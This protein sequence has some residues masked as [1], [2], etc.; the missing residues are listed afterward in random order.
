[1]FSPIALQ[2][3]G[4]CVERLGLWAKT[5]V[6]ARLFAHCWATDVRPGS[7]ARGAAPTLARKLLTQPTTSL[8]PSAVAA[9]AGVVSAT[10]GR[11]MVMIATTSLANFG[12]T[13]A[14]FLSFGKVCRAIAV[15]A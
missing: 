5:P 13:T 14:P 12:P 2:P 11:A 4:A 10:I 8:G 9:R 7:A 15:A 1:M 3:E 6:L